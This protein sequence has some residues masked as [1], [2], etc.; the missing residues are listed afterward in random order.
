[1]QTVRLLSLYSTQLSPPKTVVVFDQV[2]YGTVNDFTKV[3]S[4]MLVYFH[5]IISDR[6][7]LAFWKET[8]KFY[9]NISDKQNLYFYE[10]RQKEKSYCLVAAA[11]IIAYSKYSFTYSL[12]S[13][14]LSMYLSSISAQARLS[15]SAW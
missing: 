14:P 5:Y 10:I 3:S 7:N 4:C 9:Y 1:M 2:L 15:L 11:L 8:L 12:T 13:T 6:Q